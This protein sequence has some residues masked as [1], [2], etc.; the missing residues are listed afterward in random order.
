[1]YIK[2]IARI[3]KMNAK[4]KNIKKVANSEGGKKERKEHGTIVNVAQIFSYF[5]KMLR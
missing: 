2:I 1:M 4:K 3:L 5:N